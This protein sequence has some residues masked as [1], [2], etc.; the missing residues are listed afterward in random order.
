MEKGYTVAIKIIYVITCLL[1]PLCGFAQTQLPHPQPGVTSP[2][3]IQGINDPLWKTITSWPKNIS[4][5]KITYSVEYRGNSIKYEGQRAT[6]I[7]EINKKQRY[8]ANYSPNYYDDDVKE[9]DYY[10]GPFFGWRPDGTLYLKQM[11]DEYGNHESYYL[12]PD[13]SFCQSS[14]YDRSR[15][16]FMISYYENDGTLIGYYIIQNEWTADKSMESEYWWDGEFVSE[17]E[18]KSLSCG[19]AKNCLSD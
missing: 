10:Y 6:D 4:K 5:G 2:S 1:I 18:L 8:S 16:L 9:D 11:T 12:Y 15:D 17:E 3:E 7:D 13:G 19:F 14:I